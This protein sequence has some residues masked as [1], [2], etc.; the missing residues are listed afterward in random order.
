MNSNRFSVMIM[1]ICYIFSVNLKNGNSGFSFLFD[2]K[3][4]EVS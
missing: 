4:V 1:G 2:I 3:C